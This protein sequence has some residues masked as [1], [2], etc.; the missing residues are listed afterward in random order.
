MV[1]MMVEI[2]SRPPHRRIRR[3]TPPCVED[4]IWR[5]TGK[6]TIYQMIALAEQVTLRGGAPLDPLEYKKLYLDR[7]Y[8]ASASA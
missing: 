8:A 7:L 4:F 6:Q 3:R 2:L 1:P 5:L